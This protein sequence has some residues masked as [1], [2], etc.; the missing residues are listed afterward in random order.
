MGEVKLISIREFCNS[1]KIEPTF[2]QSLR[3]Y[4]LIEVKIVDK[5]HFVKEDHLDSLE[6]MVRLHRDL[7]INLEGIDAIINLLDKVS[8]LK[9][10]VRRLQV[11]V[12]RHEK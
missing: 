10:E 4:D 3:E 9:E 7:N 2:I 12:D 6:K 8:E 5:A 11:R 1:H